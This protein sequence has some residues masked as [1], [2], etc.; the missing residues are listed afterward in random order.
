MT[1]RDYHGEKLSEY[2]HG[3]NLRVQWGATIRGYHREKDCQKVPWGDCQ[4]VPVRER[5]SEGI[6][7][8]DLGGYIVERLSEDNMQRDCQQV[9]YCI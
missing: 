5:L 2:T 1:V 8:G 6:R 3:E 4:R 9:S 7:E